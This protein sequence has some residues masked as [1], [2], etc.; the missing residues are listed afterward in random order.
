MPYFNS[1]KNY[2]VSVVLYST[3]ILRSFFDVFAWTIYT[4]LPK[5]TT[6]WIFC[7]YFSSNWGLI[8]FYD[9]AFIFWGILGWFSCWLS[10]RRHG[11]RLLITAWIRS[12]LCRSFRG[13]MWNLHLLFSVA[14][15]FF[16]WLPLFF[17]SHL[18][19]VLSGVL[20]SFRAHWLVISLA[21][22]LKCSGTFRFNESQSK[23]GEIGWCSESESARAIP[24]L[25][26][27]RRHE[28]LIMQ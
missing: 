16:L 27:P 15:R 7:R 19:A 13:Q 21:E 25:Q 26:K 14:Y 18:F 17:P 1:L 3:R 6:Y 8:L 20:F 10:D 5:S 12:V 4:K 28:I 2:T 23:P 22:D 9:F 24:Q 11:R